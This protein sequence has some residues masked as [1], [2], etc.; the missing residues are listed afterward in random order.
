M[1]ITARPRGTDSARVI[2]VIETKS[3]RGM[4]TEE[5]MSR[6]VMQY[7]SLKGEL[8]AENDGMFDNLHAKERTGCSSDF[9]TR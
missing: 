7:W 2:E 8:L 6:Y 1:N 9:K 4:G 5:D 3:V